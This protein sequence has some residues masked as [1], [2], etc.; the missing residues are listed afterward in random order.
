M[1]EDDDSNCIIVIIDPNNH[2]YKSN[3]RVKSESVGATGPLGPAHRRGCH[4]GPRDRPQL[5]HEPRQRGL[6]RGGHGRARRLR[7]GRRHGVSLSGGG[8]GSRAAGPLL[9]NDDRRH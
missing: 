3:V 4:H 1:I 9:I 2:H 8:L 7:D 6:L 5:R